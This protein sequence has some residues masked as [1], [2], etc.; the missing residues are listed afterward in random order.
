VTHGYLK[1]KTGRPLLRGIGIG[2]L[3]AV[4]VGA[5]WWVSM[6]DGGTEATEGDTTTTTPNVVAHPKQV[7]IPVGSYENRAGAKDN[8]EQAHRQFG[9]AGTLWSSDY[10]NL[11]P[12]WW[13]AYVG[14]WPHTKEGLAAAEAVR[15]RLPTTG[16]TKKFNV[17]TIQRRA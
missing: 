9:R 5:W 17:V 3:L 10:T 12:K 2:L 13:V 15:R 6:R 8:A 4:L 1:Y 14:P 7:I 16:R 11:R